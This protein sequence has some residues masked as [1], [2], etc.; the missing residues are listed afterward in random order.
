MRRTVCG[1]TL[2]LLLL[3]AAVGCGASEDNKQGSQ[4]DKKPQAAPQTPKGVWQDGLKPAKK[5]GTVGT[6]GTPCVL[7]VA[8]DLAASWKPQP[9]GSQD[10]IEAPTQGPVTLTCEIDAKP[11]GNV[12]FLRV[13]S[14]LSGDLRA[15]Q[16]LDSFLAEEQNVSKPTFRETRAGA[17]PAT[18][19]T[20]LTQPLPEDEPKRERALSVELPHG[21]VVL[22]LGGMDTAEHDAMLP[23]Y[24]LARTS[25]TA[26]GAV[27]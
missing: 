5:A 17:L 19:A 2:S 21:A 1:A 16:A 23:A 24:E 14:S 11:A 9:V 7:P 13:W 27:P 10:I 4:Q 15:R 3:G 20:Y 25:L 12:G 6:V 18:E 8:F 22:H 26:T